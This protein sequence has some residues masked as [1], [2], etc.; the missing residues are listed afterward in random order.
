MRRHNEKALRRCNMCRGSGT[1]QKMTNLNPMPQPL[2]ELDDLDP[3]EYAL[4]VV[5]PYWMGGLEQRVRYA[6]ERTGF[7]IERL[8]TN[9]DDSMVTFSVRR[10]RPLPHLENLDAARA[11]LQAA[12][13]NA[14]CPCGEQ[15]LALEVAD[16]Q[17]TGAY[18]PNPT[19]DN[20]NPMHYVNALLPPYNP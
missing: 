7:E 15:E 5:N 18:V 19:E 10:G 17:W 4:R 16:D 8:V 20:L 1:P 13:T 6:L 3:K 12:L 11:A 14:G 9:P 2:H